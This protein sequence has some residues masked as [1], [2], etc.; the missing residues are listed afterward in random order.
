MHVKDFYF[1]KMIF[2]VHRISC[3]RRLSTGH[4]DF[5]IL[6]PEDL[7]LAGSNTEYDILVT[8]ELRLF[9][10]GN[11]ISIIM[12]EILYFYYTHLFISNTINFEIFRNSKLG[13]SHDFVDNDFQKLLIPE[14]Y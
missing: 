8:H 4:A 3:L 13:N 1:V 12:A 11:I 5:A 6:E 9:K 2:H 14:I 10:N 7:V